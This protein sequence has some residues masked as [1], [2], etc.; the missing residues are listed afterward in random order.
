MISFISK[1]QDETTGMVAPKSPAWSV[2]NFV[3]YSHIFHEDSKLFPCI[4][5]IPKLLEIFPQG[6]KCGRI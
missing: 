1:W 5:E 2:F 6:K 3:Q 4:V